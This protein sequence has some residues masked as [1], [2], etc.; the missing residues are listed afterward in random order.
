MLDRILDT[1]ESPMSLRQLQT[2]ASA[3]TT[4]TRRD[5]LDSCDMRDNQMRFAHD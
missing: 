4:C 1:I 5:V 3:L 2:D